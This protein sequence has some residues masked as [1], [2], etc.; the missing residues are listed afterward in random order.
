MQPFGANSLAIYR[1]SQQA[2]DTPMDHPLLP[3]LWQNFFTLFLARVS[4]TTGYA[5]NIYIVSHI[6]QWY[7]SYSIVSLLVLWIKEA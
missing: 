5:T 2:L 7:K 6:R 3:L 4:S 1:W